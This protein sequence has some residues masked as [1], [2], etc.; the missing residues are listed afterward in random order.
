MRFTRLAML[1]SLSLLGACQGG[2]RPDPD[3]P[4]PNQFGIDRAETSV[5][6]IAAGA[7]AA[8][9]NGALLVGYN[10]LAAHLGA[11][12]EQH[13]SDYS[14]ALDL[15]RTP[16]AGLTEF[17]PSSPSSPPFL[18][19]G[20]VMG[21]ALP[22]GWRTKGDP[23]VGVSTPVQTPNGPASAGR[24]VYASLIEC[25]NPA[26]CVNT[27]PSNFSDRGV[28]VFR[29]DNCGASWQVAI[30]PVDSAP[31]ATRGTLPNPLNPAAPFQV[32]SFDTP[33]LYVDPVRNNVVYV[34]ETSSGGPSD[35]MFLIA[36]STDGGA[37]FGGGFH[38]V[39]VTGE[40]SATVSAFT[41]PDGRFPV[42]ASRGSTQAQ[43]TNPPMAV[44]YTMDSLML[45]WQQF[46]VGGGAPGH[47]TRW[48]I[49][50]SVDEGQSWELPHAIDPME[51]G[52]P[53]G[54]FARSGN[55]L[56]SELY[57]TL[58]RPGFVVTPGG[59]AVVAVSRRNEARMA[60]QVVVFTSADTLNWQTGLE[61][62]LGTSNDNESL[63]D[64]KDQFQPVLVRDRSG[65]SD[66]VVLAWYDAR[67]SSDRTRM[68][69]YSLFSAWGG[70]AG[71]WVG[72]GATQTVPL[73]PAGI[74]GAIRRV[75][76]ETWVPHLLAGG[77]YGE[78]IG[79]DVV[80]NPAGEPHYVFAW[81]DSRPSLAVP[82]NPNVTSV[83]VA[84]VGLEQPHE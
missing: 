31:G 40:T 35:H 70:L 29:S 11:S 66:Q 58:A 6:T 12:G 37:T 16:D 67:E 1:T 78:Y 42:L 51:A 49:S 59:V 26:T 18:Q 50:R 60:E 38:R 41:T 46:P 62:P 7:N 30:I 21:A 79:G 23:S 48:M 24:L 15:N 68:G 27:Q 2:T 43:S 54:I 57:N 63:N 8:C 73:T 55:V 84:T 13:I 61:V 72:T 77:R 22:A 76:R 74:R 52:S 39:A 20:S 10:G 75:S 4:V 44:T 81:A 34:V 64:G 33:F 3:Q 69:V 36:K 5:A 45:V 17:H 47:Y 32:Q 83:V 28:A 80:F 53:G 56:A 9:P 65:A 71:T 82:T 25:I 19:N 14:L